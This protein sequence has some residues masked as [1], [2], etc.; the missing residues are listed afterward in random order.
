MSY[1]G[2][3]LYSFC[4]VCGNRVAAM[5]CGCVAECEVCRLADEVIIEGK[6]GTGQARRD[7]LG[8]DYNDVQNEIN[9]R[10]GYSK[11]Y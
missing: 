10:L 4:E 11:R 2:D 6:H 7:S 8:D 1:K 3:G 5:E 9:R